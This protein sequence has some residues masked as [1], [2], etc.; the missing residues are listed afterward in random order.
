LS[1]TLIL[2]PGKGG[3]QCT[4][5]AAMC[6][7]VGGAKIVVCVNGFSDTAA[8]AGAFAA[9]A[10][11]NHIQVAGWEL[12]NE[13]YTIPSIFPTSTNYVAQMKPYRDAITA[14]DSNAVVAIY[15]DDAGYPEPATWDTELSN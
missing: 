5:F 10:L 13:P 11:S 4:D 7:N 9:F 8:S 14:A 6:A 2:L 15:F 3:A 12:C 1:S